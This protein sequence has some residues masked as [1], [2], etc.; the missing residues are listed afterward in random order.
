[1]IRAERRPDKSIETKCHG[2][3]EELLHEAS[4]VLANVA[5]AVAEATGMTETQVL[6]DVVTLATYR[7]SRE[8]RQNI[9]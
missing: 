7:L 6:A 5:E 2:T 8:Q 1:M 3:A 9:S 4:G